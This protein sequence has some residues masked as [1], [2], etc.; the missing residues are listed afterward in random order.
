MMKSIAD[1]KKTEQKYVE[2]K[3]ALKKFIQFDENE[4]ENETWF[5]CFRNGFSLYLIPS[6]HKQRL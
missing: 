4:N 1:W 5:V 6:D 3:N 2:A